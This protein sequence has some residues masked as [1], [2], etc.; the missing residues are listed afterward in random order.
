[1]RISSVQAVVSLILVRKLEADHC[2]GFL[3]FLIA[4]QIAGGERLAPRQVARPPMQAR[5]R[6]QPSDKWWIAWPQTKSQRKPQAT[7]ACEYC[8]DP[9]SRRHTWRQLLVK[10]R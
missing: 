7:T 5:H 1:M 8:H 3:R 10:R 2:T 9:N 6:P 4:E